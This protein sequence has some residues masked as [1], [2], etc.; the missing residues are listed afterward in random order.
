MN[1]SRKKINTCVL[2]SVE[3]I[4]FFGLLNVFLVQVLKR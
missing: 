1:A 3:T 2:K 4:Y